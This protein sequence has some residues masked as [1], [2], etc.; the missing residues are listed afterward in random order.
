M[1]PSWVHSKAAAAHVKTCRENYL[2]LYFHLSHLY[3]EMFRMHRVKKSSKC[4]PLLIRFSIVVSSLHYSDIKNSVSSWELA[5]WW[6][7]SSWDS[8]W[9]ASECPSSRWFITFTTGKESI[10]D[11]VWVRE[12][13]ALVLLQFITE[14]HLSLAASLV[15]TLWSRNLQ[16]RV[17]FRPWLPWD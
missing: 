5:Y 13:R 4:S 2:L 10:P 8:Q 12:L 1:Q 11:D 9:E 3:A 17:C 16:N 14:T 15:Y 6:V 7:H